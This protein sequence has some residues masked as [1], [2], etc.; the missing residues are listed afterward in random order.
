MTSKERVLAALSHDDPDLI[1][2]DFGATNATGI[3]A[4]AYDQLLQHLKLPNKKIRIYNVLLMLTEPDEAVDQHFQVDVKQ[5]PRLK[6]SLNLRIDRYKPYPWNGKSN[7]YFP[8]NFDPHYDAAGSAVLLNDEGT[9]IA[10]MPKDGLYFDMLHHPL[11][12]ARSYRDIDRIDFRDLDREEEHWLA[13]ESKRLAKTDYAVLGYFG[14]FFFG[15][16]SRYFGMENFLIRLLQE[17]K[18]IEHFFSRVLQAYIDDFDRYIKAVDGRVQIIQVSDDLGGQTGPLIS[19]DTYKR[20]VKPY[21][22]R[23]YRHIRNKSDACLFLHSCGGVYQFISHFIEM[24]VQVLNPVQYTASGMDPHR[25]KRE[26]GRDIA[27]W[28]GGCDT[29]FVIEEDSLNKIEAETAKMIDTLA[30][31]GGF[32]FS[33]VHNIQPGVSPEKIIAIYDTIIKKRGEYS[34]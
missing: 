6:P 16:G 1:P 18:L 19:I 5:L 32:V 8:S 34:G 17:P 23:L 28:G 11:A 27:F 10:R 3:H 7:Y 22:S 9:A 13:E 15:K 26:F 4:Y 25:L 33:Q 14:G 30:P 2:I 24:G 20:M 21:Q 31:G 12:D 29:Q